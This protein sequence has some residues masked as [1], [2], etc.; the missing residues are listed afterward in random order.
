M[1]ISSKGKKKKKKKKRIE[2]RLRGIQSRIAKGPNGQLLNLECHLRKEYFEVLHYEEFWSVKSKYNWL[3]Q[4][5]R[6]TSFFHT[7]ALIRRRSILCLKDSLGN[8]VQGESDIV[9]LIKSGFIKLFSTSVTSVPRMRWSL[10]IWPSLLRNE[11]ACILSANLTKLEVK[12]GL[13]S[14][15]PLKAP[16]PDGI[17]AGFF[18]AYWQQVGTSVVYEVFKVFQGSTMPPHLN[19]TLITL[20]PKHPQADCLASFRPI[21]LC[22]TVYKVVTKDIVKRLRP[23]LPKLISPLQTTFVPGRMGL[24]NMIIAQ[25]LI[26]TMMLKKGKT[27]FMAIKIYLEKTYDRLEW[28]FIRDVLEL[29]KLPPSLIKL[30]MSCVSSSSISMLFNGGKLEPFH[31][32][33]GIRQGDPLSPYLFIMCMEMLGFL[34][35]RRC[36]ENLWDPVRASRGGQAFS[37]LF[38]ADNLV[39]FAKADLRNCNSM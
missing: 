27:G 31:P 12:E 22:N 35:S 34:I 5:D 19:E 11:D 21:S 4:G 14:L 25:E 15:K 7:S 20:T 29:Y 3:I 16:G 33:R 36:E 24:D 32:S 39:F 37:H 30:I 28:H 13:E 38:F 6:N 18:Q 10:D 23:F 26:H 8:W 2:A 9:E 1:E 17:H